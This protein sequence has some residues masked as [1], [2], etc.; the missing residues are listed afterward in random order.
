MMAG[1]TTSAVESTEPGGTTQP[2][3]RH[4]IAPGIS[5]AQLGKRAII[6]RAFLEGEKLTRLEARDQY[7]DGCL[8]TTVATIQRTHPV[9]VDRRLEVALCRGNST[10]WV[11]RYWLSRGQRGAGLAAFVDELRRAG[12]ACDAHALLAILVGEK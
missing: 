10:C 7:S 8:K 11:A 6:L 2:L 3:R 12:L 5:D 1:G 9:R 4:R